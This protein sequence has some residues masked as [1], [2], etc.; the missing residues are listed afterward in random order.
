MSL[1]K[2]KIF[3]DSLINLFAAIV[4]LVILQLVILPLMASSMGD[5]EYGFALTILSL[6]NVCPSVFGNTLNNVRLVS[7]RSYE[8]L[9]EKGDF[10][11]LLAGCMVV[12]VVVVIAGTVYYQGCFNFGSFL[13]VA[14]SMLWLM[15][16]YLVVAYLE[17]LE[18]R[19][20]L[21]NN[22]LLSLGYFVGLAVFYAGGAW[23]FVY[24]FGNV[25]S[26][27]FVL[28]TTRIWREPFTKTPLFGKTFRDFLELM[29]SG[30]MGR[31]VTYAD[32]LLLY[33]LL[34]G[35]LVSVYY[36]ATLFGK[37]VSV[38]VSPV[39]NV[40]LSHLSSSDERDTRSFFV[41]F[42]FGFVVCTIGCIVV[43]LVSRPFLDV[44][45]PQFVDAAM[46]YV[47]IATVTSF[48]SALSTLINPFVLRFSPMKWQM[49]FS[50]ATVVVYI[51][52]SLAL[53]GP[54]GLMG[55]CFGVLAS[56]IV[57]LAMQ[58]AVYCASFVSR[59]R[60]L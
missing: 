11:P 44:L 18:Y 43:V 22:L 60:Q 21:A 53:L 48:V 13:I 8:R 49:A 39:S 30:L 23:E 51:S 52:L 46:P 33:P 37:V 41:T 29:V 15:R 27:A 7:K 45:Y 56:N 16:E 6:L 2:R 12:N 35:T 58:V 28:A 25:L 42:A 19:G 10:G 40:L 47:L 5:N 31:L 4:P 3:T 24:F 34:G 9:G 17:K 14:T 36:V 1:R 59:S 57:R 54:F 20:I 26:M 55:F 32:R 50:A 38:V